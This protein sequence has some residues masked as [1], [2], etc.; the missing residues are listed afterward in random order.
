MPEELTKEEVEAEIDELGRRLERLRVLYEQY[1]LGIER[2]PPTQVQKD[3]VR[4]VYRLSQLHFKAATSKFRFQAL[5]QRFN[6]H[7]AYWARTSREIEQGTYKRLTFRAKQREKRHVAAG[8]LTAADHLAIRTVRDTLGEEAA[9]KAETQRRAA[10]QAELADAATDFMN[11]MGGGGGAETSSEPPKPAP[12]PADGEPRDSPSGDAAVM[13]GVSSE[14]LV[15]RAEKL[16]ALQQRMRA[17]GA[18]P[19]RRAE[20]TASRKAEASGP[21]S[22]VE[23]DDRSIYE[24]LVAAK[25]R[26]NQDID[27]LNFEKVSKSL[28]KQR[29]KARSKH[30]VDRVDFD[31]VVKDGQ[32]F[33]KAIP[34]KE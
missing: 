13:R 32:A 29:D 5:I 27:N 24:R 9:D 33:L 1:F 34:I 16:R 19:K 4:R 3:V 20:A 21:A 23:S 15:K 31:V 28:E 26:L 30:G 10:R 7:K 8:E 12:A 14:D 2:T 18:G 6:A 25:Q 22:R 11:Q 17:P